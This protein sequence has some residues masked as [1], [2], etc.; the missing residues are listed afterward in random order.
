MFKY[1]GESI[2]LMPKRKKEAYPQ[3]KTVAVAASIWKR[4]GAFVVDVLIVYVIVLFALGDKILPAVDDAA[5]FAE[6][7]AAMAESPGIADGVSFIFSILM[8]V[9]YILLER[10][11]GQ[12]IGKMVVNIYVV[13][14]LPDKQAVSTLQ[15]IGRSM[16]LIPMFPF[17]LLWLID[18]IAML[19]TK[20]NQRISEKLSNTKVVEHREIV[21]M[22]NVIV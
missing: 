11:F 18:P 3:P 19:F 14:S 17:M 21:P 8:L 5:S 15:H 7:Y 6:T 12:S 4:I 10:K 1:G 2:A 22:E 16:F 9:Y 20:D 13:P